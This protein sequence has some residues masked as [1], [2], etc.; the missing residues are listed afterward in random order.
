MQEFIGEDDLETFEGWVRYQGFD[1][2]TLAP[3]EL[4][5]WRDM[6]DKLR[7]DTLAIPKV[8]LMKL[9]RVHWLRNGAG[10][11]CRCWWA[12]V[13]GGAGADHRGGTAGVDQFPRLI[14]VVSDRPNLTLARPFWTC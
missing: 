8:G 6:F 3:D 4:A 9:P 7:K 1:A 11:A 14:L 10:R 5:E 2:T 13:R 12:H